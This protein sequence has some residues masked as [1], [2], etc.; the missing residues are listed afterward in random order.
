SIS[1]SELHRS[2]S[3]SVCSQ[4]L[5]RQ[6]SGQFQQRG[7]FKVERK[8]YPAEHMLVLAVDTHVTHNLSASAD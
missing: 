7:R 8:T 4:R 1:T 2:S 6:P 5:G 3:I